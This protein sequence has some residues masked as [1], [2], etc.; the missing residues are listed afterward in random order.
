M[1]GWQRATGVDGV[2]RDFYLRQL[3]DW[4]GSAELETML[5][6]AMVEYARMCG[7]TLA[8]GHARSGDRIAIAAY[9]GKSDAFD[10]AI[11]EFSRVYADRNEA[12]Y[13]LLKEAG[14]SGRVVVESGV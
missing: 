14:D 7:W 9:L 1:L 11:L 12:D 13:A 2:E 6:A 4:K 10:R 5:P 8:R 3:K